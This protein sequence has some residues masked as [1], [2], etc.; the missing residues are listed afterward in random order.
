MLT[1][2]FG[3]STGYISY[4]IY[5]PIWLTNV[6]LMLLCIWN[7]GGYVLRTGDAAKKYLAIC[8]VFFIIPTILTSMFFGLGAPPY[9]SPKLWV[10]SITEQRTRYYFLL[11]AGLFISFASAMLRQNLKK[12]GENLFSL[13]GYTAVKTAVPIFLIN[14]TFWGFYLTKLYQ[15]MVTSNAEITPEW[16]IPLRNQFYYINVIACALFYLGTA[17]FAISL[18]CTRLF[19]KNASN[20]YIFLSLSFFL[21][22]VLPPWLPEPFATLNFIVSIPAVPFFFS[23]FIGVNLLKKIG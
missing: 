7:L 18:R 1:V 2:I 11:T 6:L 19:R 20:V 23:Y 12:T 9:E 13:L 17:A 14:M 10:A 5:L 21:L 4:K 15:G 8:A 16:L 22:D 3:L